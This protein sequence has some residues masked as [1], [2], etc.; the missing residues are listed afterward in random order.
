MAQN[1]AEKTVRL[2][3]DSNVILSGLISSQ[4]APRILLDLLSL[5]V[6]LLIGI[7]GQYNLEEIERNLKSRFPQLLSVFK[8]YLPRMRLEII[9]IPPFKDVTPLVKKMS[10]KDAPVLAS[11][12]HAKA[13]YLITGDKKGFPEK[14]AKP[15]KIISP[16]KFLNEVLS[17]LIYEDAK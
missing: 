15:I 6:P 8:D 9:D 5:D 2:Y 17:K 4:G 11:A 3:L 7:T 10:P 12:Q 1:A 16:D 13:D 14:V